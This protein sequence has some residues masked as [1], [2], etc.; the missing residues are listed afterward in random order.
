MSHKSKSIKCLVVIIT[1]F[2]GSY[3]VIADDNLTDQAFESKKMDYFTAL[4]QQI[5]D[6]VSNG[7][8]DLKN[9]FK[10]GLIKWEGECYE[11]DLNLGVLVFEASAKITEE[12]IRQRQSFGKPP[13]FDKIEI[14]DLSGYSFSLDTY[15]PPLLRAYILLRYGPYLV[16]IEE[17]D[18]LLYKEELNSLPLNSVVVLE[19]ACYLM[20]K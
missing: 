5:N 19:R 18:V 11:R 3:Y 4:N 7:K 2:L 17:Q 20:K 10:K 16:Q 15:N 12:I 8:V 9:L 14:G 6:A 13:V 1:L